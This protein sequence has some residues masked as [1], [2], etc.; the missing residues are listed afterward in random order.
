MGLSEHACCELEHQLQYRFNNK[1]LLMQAMTHRSMHHE[2]YERLEFLGDSVLGMIVSDVLYQR[3]PRVTEGKLSRM[4]ASLVCGRNLSGLSRT[5]GLGNYVQ[6]GSGELKSGGF[7]RDSILSDILEAVI[8]AMYLD[9]DWAQVRRFILRIL[10]QKLLKIRSDTDFRDPKTRLQELLQQHKQALPTYQV[11]A[12]SGQD[13]CKEFEVICRID[14]D[15]NFTGL[16]RSRRLAEQQAAE[17][18]LQFYK[19][20]VVEELDL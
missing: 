11:V 16:G 5:L 10:Q 2:N 20:V 13:H 15:Y 3:F 8:G 12:T 1:Q 14:N 6:L 7:E 17:Q 19:S 18:A 9:S 4:R